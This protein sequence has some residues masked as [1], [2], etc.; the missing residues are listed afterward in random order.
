MISC[1]DHET[2]I[3]MAR[4]EEWKRITALVDQLKVVEGEEQT[5]LTMFAFELRT[6]LTR[7]RGRITH[8]WNEV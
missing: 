8:D 2:V 3:T 1:V 7:G 5:L 6:E 4:N